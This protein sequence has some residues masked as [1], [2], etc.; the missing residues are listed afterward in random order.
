VADTRRAGWLTDRWGLAVVLPRWKDQVLS[1]GPTEYYALFSSKKFYKIDTVVFSF[2]FD[3]N[4]L[5]MD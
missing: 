5:I 3:K 1:C 2:V 4:C